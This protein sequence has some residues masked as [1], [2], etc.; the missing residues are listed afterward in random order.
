MVK[1]L[2]LDTSKVNSNQVSSKESPSIS[3]QLGNLDPKKHN[4]MMLRRFI[5]TE[6]G[7]VLILWKKVYFTLINPE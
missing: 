3:S 2:R 1:T 5:S 7:C 6:V 4:K